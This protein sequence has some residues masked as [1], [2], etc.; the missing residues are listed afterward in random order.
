MS[1]QATETKSNGQNNKASSLVHQT[2]ASGN[3]QHN[4]SGGGEDDDDAGFSLFCCLFGCCGTSSNSIYNN[5][6]DGPYV[7]PTSML[8][9]KLSEDKHKKT[10][11]VD[12][13]ETLVHSTFQPAEK[14][15]IVLPINIEGALYR[16]YVRIRPFA[17]EFLEEM[18][19]HFE[20]VL[21]TASLQKYADP[22][23]DLLDK[24]HC[25]RS[26]LFRRHCTYLSSSG[27]FVKD[28]SRMG[29]QMSDILLIDNS[30]L[31]Y[32][33][34]PENG[35]PCTSFIDDPSDTELKDIIPFLIELAKSHDVRNDTKKWKR[36]F[37]VMY[38]NRSKEKMESKK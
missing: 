11:V 9:P 21:F 14:A 29:R 27:A 24:S 23:L 34:Q 7:S 16:V 10:L 30:P 33:L 4:R 35:V 32:S 13:D 17:K 26:R 20:I 6:S 22:L 28:L 12:L 19:K 15:D 1:K 38:Q 25:I 31:S 8:P 5:R 37:N 18:S 36:H 2:D 3:Q